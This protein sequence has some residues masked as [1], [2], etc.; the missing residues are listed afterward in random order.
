MR[1]SALR[2]NRPRHIERLSYGRAKDGPT[3][4][5]PPAFDKLRSPRATSRG[6]RFDD[7]TPVSPRSTRTPG[8]VIPRG[9]QSGPGW[10]TA[11]PGNGAFRLS[12][13]YPVI[14]AFHPYGV[15]RYSKNLANDFKEAIEHLGEFLVRSPT[16]PFADALG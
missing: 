4:V 11:N 3:P 14:G 8:G 15:D 5:W 9:R 12:T 10:R 6:G 16:Y 1:D 13:E 2:S 7:G